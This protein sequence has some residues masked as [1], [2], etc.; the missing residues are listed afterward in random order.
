[1]NLPKGAGRVIPKVFLLA[2]FGFVV[3]PYHGSLSNLHCHSSMHIQEVLQHDFRQNLRI[4]QKIQEK[5]VGP[6][7]APICLLQILLVSYLKEFSLDMKI[8]N[9]NKDRHPILLF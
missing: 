5:R 7:R 3:F 6:L 2:F 8:L 1:M 9:V 4:T